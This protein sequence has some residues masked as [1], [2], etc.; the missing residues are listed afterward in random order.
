MPCVT[1]SNPDPVPPGMALNIYELLEKL[2]EK[3]PSP[4]FG[5]ELPSIEELKDKIGEYEESMGPQVFN[6][7]EDYLVAQ[8][9]QRL[10]SKRIT[11]TFPQFTPW[12]KPLLQ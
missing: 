8:N 7:P 4:W 5:P 3:H 9:T 6:V 12:K 1:P 10:Y 2:T 11:S